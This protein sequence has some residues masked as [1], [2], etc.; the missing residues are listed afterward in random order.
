MT[1]LIS[2]GDASSETAHVIACGDDI[3]SPAASRPITSS[4]YC[5]SAAMERM[6]GSAIGFGAPNSLPS[7]RWR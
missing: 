5:P 7:T 2:S 4:V 6:S 1:S 3:H